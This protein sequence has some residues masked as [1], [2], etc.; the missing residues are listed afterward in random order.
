V[1]TCLPH[2]FVEILA[3]QLPQQLPRVPPPLLLVPV[4]SERKQLL[5]LLVRMLLLLLLLHW[6][7]APVCH[8]TSAAA[9]LP[10][11]SSRTAWAPL[12]SPLFLLLGAAA[13]FNAA[14]NSW[15]LL[16]HRLLW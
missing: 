16:A 13:A 6:A 11:V 12:L 3:Q 4:V 9:G 14:F 10:A 1:C 15:L 8:A 7:C 5:L 2:G